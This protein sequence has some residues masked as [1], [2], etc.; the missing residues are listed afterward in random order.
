MNSQKYTFQKFSINTRYEKYLQ[1]KIADAQSDERENLSKV[2]LLR[3]VSVKKTIHYNDRAIKTSTNFI[4]KIIYN[5][6]D[7]CRR[8][9][10]FI[11][12]YLKLTV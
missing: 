1:Q 4:G 7:N 9:F 10:K 6:I 8:K 3:P 5:V 2:P 12:I 11:K